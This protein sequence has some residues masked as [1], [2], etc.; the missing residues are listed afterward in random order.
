MM[1]IMEKYLNM[2]MKK[3]TI[4]IKI[5]AIFIANQKKIKKGEKLMVPLLIA[6]NSYDKKESIS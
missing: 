6:K 3:K 2:M 5:M 1:I 4:K